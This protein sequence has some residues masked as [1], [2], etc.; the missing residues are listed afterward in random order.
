MFY[1]KYIVQVQT[2]DKDGQLSNA[3]FFDDFEGKIVLFDS[4]EDAVN[5]VQSFC[6]DTQQCI[7]LFNDVSDDFDIDDNCYIDF[8][9][10]QCYLDTDDEA[11]AR[12]EHIS[13][14]FSV[15]SKPVKVLTYKFEKT[16][17]GYLSD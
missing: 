3:L 1:E 10:G 17:E 15:P 13:V 5:S 2:C 12:C 9:V 8:L 16:I 6:F 14:S 4:L 7:D 11:G